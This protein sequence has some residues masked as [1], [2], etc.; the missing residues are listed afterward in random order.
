MRWKILELAE[1]SNSIDEIINELGSDSSYGI[2]EEEILQILKLYQD[3]FS[4]KLQKEILS[5]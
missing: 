4:E 3:S 5:R 1:K 2:T